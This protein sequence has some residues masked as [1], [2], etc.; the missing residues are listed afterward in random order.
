V[1]ALTAHL[2]G[3][4]LHVVYR[5]AN[6]LL[7]DRLI[8]DMRRD[9]ALGTIAKGSAGA[10]E[11][12]RLLREGDSIGMLVDQKMNDGIAVPFFGRD[13]MTAPAPAQLALRYDLPLIPVRCERLDGAC[14]RVSF[15]PPLALP[16]DMPRQEAIRALT[17]Q[18]NTALEEWI[19][20][21]PGQ[22]LWLHR[23]WP[24]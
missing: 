6:N 20:T 3:L 14:F 11:I 24:D 21:R 7:V 1:T 17:A 5:Q 10:R 19:R 15:H 4:Q 12:V 13:A 9:L 2:L 23:R 8:Q 22:W 18:I 16:A